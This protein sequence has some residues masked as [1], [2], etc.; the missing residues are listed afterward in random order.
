MTLKNKYIL[1][2]SLIHTICLVL[3]YY[4]FKENKF[5][6]VVAEVCI[7]LSIGFSLVLYRQMIQP[8]RLLVQ[9]AEAIRDQDFNVKFVST[10]NNEMAQ[11]VGI[12]N[13]MMD[14]L[15]KERTKQEEQHFFLDKLIK[16]TPIGIIILDFDKKIQEVNPKAQSIL[17]SEGM[18]VDESNPM[19]TALLK[20]IK[21][22]LPGTPSYL[23]HHARQYKLQISHFL[24]R[25]FQRYFI[26]LEELT[27]E[28]AKAE[29]QAYTKVIRMMSHEVNNT[30]GPV[31]SI[32]QSAL[33]LRSKQDNPDALSHAFQVA[34]ERN[35]N[36]NVFTRN[37]ANVVRIPEPEL[38]RIDVHK[39]IGNVVT[40]FE[41]ITKEK[42]IQI[43]YYPVNWPFYI[44]AD[45]SQMEQVLI[46]VIKNSVEA[47]GS[48]VYGKIEI[49]TTLDPAKIVIRD[50]G[51]G[52][53][54]KES[55]YLFPAFFTTK[56][57]GQGIGLTMSKE[58][59][60]N[61][62]FEFSLS[63]VNFGNTEF[64]IICNMV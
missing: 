25:G 42:K 39:L 38:K 34:I 1:F 22:L 51:H 46:N 16:T 24:D 49:R 23:V 30:I 44:Q 45:I 57:H 26:T 14:E 36:L 32:L 50:T 63:T 35:N 61:H 53:P 62:G 48:D 5:W 10:G 21:N 31:N 59:L 55:D 64:T 40:L 13:Q 20:E 2:I 9:G 33:M 12:Y 8:L 27:E 29:K 58:I 7:I 28:I 41:E 60:R 15:R 47:I 43:Q 56:P 54:T 18:E 37:L 52:L 17:H 3:S 6:F 11:L 19:F 4:I